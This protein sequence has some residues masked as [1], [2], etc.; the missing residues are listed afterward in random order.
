LY[1]DERENYSTQFFL[2]FFLVCCLAVIIGDIRIG[3][4][5]AFGLLLS[6]RGSS[7]LFL[8]FDRLSTVKLSGS[9]L[10]KVAPKFLMT[11][12]DRVGGP[13]S[14]QDSFY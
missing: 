6:T 8:A 13:E 5:I 10:Q 1:N 14:N 2:G 12:G 9:M 3:F 4:T 11:E 7:L